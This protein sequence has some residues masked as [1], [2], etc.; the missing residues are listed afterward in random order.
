M[1]S[2]AAAEVGGGLCLWAIYKV[3]TARI[4]RT[5]VKGNPFK[6]LWYRILD[7]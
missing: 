1:V 3:L 4:A 7:T 5:L 6:V 2:V